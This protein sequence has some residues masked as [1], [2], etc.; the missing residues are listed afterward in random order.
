MIRAVLTGENDELGQIPATDVAKLIVGLQQALAAAASTVVRQKRRGSTGRHPAIIEAASRLT[1][2]GVEPGSVA[3]VFAL[4]DLSSGVADQLDVGDIPDLGQLAFDRLMDALSSN[5]PDPE[6]A[7]AVARLS[8]DLN[9][10]GHDRALRLVGDRGRVAT[11]DQSVRDRMNT[12]ARRRPVERDEQLVGSLVEADFERK[13]G[14]LQPA[15][16]PAVAVSFSDDLADRIQE[17]LRNVTQV[18]GHV[19]YDPSTHLPSR[20]DVDHVIIAEPLSDI[21][22]W[23]HVPADEQARQQGITAP[24]QIDDLHTD[25]DLTPEEIEAFFAVVDE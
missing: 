24:Q 20:V 17:S 9:V 11:I 1:F 5:D 2:Q 6:L 19:T 12:L 13:T 16:G 7:R 18:V 15:A 3:A 25:L 22:F 10:G 21:S 14:R 23:Q 4:P 8:N